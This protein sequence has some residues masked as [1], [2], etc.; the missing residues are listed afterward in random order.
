VLA[1]D[2]GND[3]LN[4][5]GGNDTLIGG[6]G[7]DTMNGG[8]GGSDV[9][10]HQAIDGPEG[11]NLGND[12]LQSF[13]LATDTVE[14]GG[15][16]VDSF[17]NLKNQMTDT[18]NGVAI[19]FT[20][21]SSVLLEGL[22]IADLT[23]ANFTVGGNPLQELSNT[24]VVAVGTS[25][26]AVNSA[27]QNAAA[28]STV[29]FKNGTHIFAD[30]L[31]VS[32]SDI[33]VKGESEAGT[34]LKFDLPAGSEGSF[35]NV[36]GGTKTYSTVLA[37]AA[38]AG[39]TTIN[40]SSSATLAVGDEVYL[41]E[42]NTQSYLDANGW[43]NVSLAEAASRPFRE[44]ITQVT[45]VNGTTVTL[46]DA[47]P[48]D[49]AA[50]ETR[51][52]EIDLL[53]SVNLQDF[54]VKSAF[55][56][57]NPFTFVNTQPAYSAT[58]AVSIVGTDG[59]GMSGI[60]VLNSPSTAITM[61]SS[62]HADVSN[63]YIKG[64][65]DKGGEGNGYG[66]ELAESFNNTLTGLEI[67]D[68]RHSLIFSAW[69][70]ETGNTAQITS[71]NR[72][73]NFH[74]SPDKGNTVT[75]DHAVLAYDTLQDPSIWSI[76]SKGGTNHAATDIFTSNSVKFIYAEGAGDVDTIH[77]ANGGSYLN[78]H[79]SNDVIYGGT[80]NDLIVGGLRRDT[81]TGNAGNDTFVLKMG[82][83]LDTIKDFVFGT[84]GDTLVFTGNPAVDGVEDLVL[85]QVG[86][87]LRVRYG[88]NST[89]IL[90]NHVA[91]DLNVTNLV[92]DPSGSNYNDEWTGLAV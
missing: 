30:S 77:G 43:T 56:D 18:A 78:G 45:A 63:I 89:V 37:S 50:V 27:I 31:D 90:E 44:F 26:A 67:F 2:S 35:I 58:S 19:A 72:D 41:F 12:L 53:D 11:S 82:D 3:V 55:A 73:V 80:G 68:T 6:F 1:G 87:D 86:A 74:G 88:V 91:A 24:I 40:V 54:T 16:G 60:S 64:S 25:A 39:S 15:M 14:I 21:G 84:G 51:V 70:A 32:R 62:T 8:T 69:N 46:A 48:Y 9:F 36:N 65:L 13:D 22:A 7:D 49:L 5:G 79:G 83:D 10:V 23:S 17:W 61:L 76:V 57:A 20:D 28:G 59:L 42:P 29:L 75:V 38:T 66:F 71:T 33:T 92:F 47:L 52:F 34:V 85:T 4:G 81:M